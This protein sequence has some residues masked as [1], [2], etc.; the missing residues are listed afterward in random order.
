MGSELNI[1]D[2][3][4]NGNDYYFEID[5]EIVDRSPIGKYSVRESEIDW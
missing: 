4:D 2:T 3:Y 1:S 5:Q